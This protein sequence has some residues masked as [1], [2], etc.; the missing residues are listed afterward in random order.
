MPFTQM[1][2]KNFSSLSFRT[3]DASK[4][5]RIEEL[6]KIQKQMIQ[7]EGEISF[8]PF[9]DQNGNATQVEVLIDGKSCPGGNVIVPDFAN[10]KSEFFFD[11]IFLSLQQLWVGLRVTGTI[12]LFVEWLKHYIHVIDNSRDYYFGLL[13]FMKFR[14][15]HS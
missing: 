3:K 11:S 1:I 14:S 5:S 6:L 10:Y 9:N 15:F 7:M 8:K 4:Q 13:A 2:M 12:D